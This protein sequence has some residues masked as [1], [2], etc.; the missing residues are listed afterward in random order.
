M[1]C[2]ICGYKLGEGATVCSNCGTRVGDDPYDKNADLSVFD[3]IESPIST[4][5]ENLIESVV[6]E[7]NSS[8]GD[9]TDSNDVFS[10][11]NSEV[12]TDLT[13]IPSEKSI[14]PSEDSSDD[15]EA[16]LFSHADVNVSSPELSKISREPVKPIL[17][18]SSDTSASV[19]NAVSEEKNDNFGDTVDNTLNS[20]DYSLDETLNNKKDAVADINAEDIRISETKRESTPVISSD[21]PKSKKKKKDK[22]KKKKNPFLIV[23]LVLGILIIGIPL[24]LLIVVLIALIVFMFTGVD[25]LTFNGIPINSKQTID[26]AYLDTIGDYYGDYHG[27]SYISD[28]YNS[29][30]LSDYLN[31]QNFSNDVN[32]LYTDLTQKEFAIS[33]Y[34]DESSNASWDML[35][36]LGD[37]FDY[38][39]F[40]NTHF[41]SYENYNDSMFE[42]GDM[43][44]IPTTCEFTIHY[45]GED[46]QDM[47]DNMLNV[48]IDERCLV[49]LNFSGK[50]VNDELSG[51][52]TVSFKYDGMEEAF[53]EVIVVNAVKD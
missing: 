41:M 52:L 25:G 42:Y 9:D 22:S 8:V 36:Y 39:S 2:N 53:K 51:I 12:D 3:S 7:K 40:D 30:L 20:S 24:L 26:T 21:K 5:N 44:V 15:L 16:V 14:N 29:Q 33:V 47:C 1:Y 11:I 10:T 19:V 38:V 45:Y 27:L 6:E 17:L 49:D 31:E 37:Y 18:K 4:Q 34:S 35:V 50:I 13:G 23:L 46:W 43:N 48:N 28:V 32:T